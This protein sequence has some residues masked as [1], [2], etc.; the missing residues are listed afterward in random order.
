M[1]RDLDQLDREH[2]ERL[3]AVYAAARAR[4]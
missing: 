1:S 3:E 4:V 2:N